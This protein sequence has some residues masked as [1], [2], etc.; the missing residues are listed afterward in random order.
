[1]KVSF[2]LAHNG[3]YVLAKMRKR[4]LHVQPLGGSQLK[5]RYDV[6]C[7]VFFFAFC[8]FFFFTFFNSLN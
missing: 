5:L 4:L 2:T 6:F 8:I 1:M 3:R 7:L